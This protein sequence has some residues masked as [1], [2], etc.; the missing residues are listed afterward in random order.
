MKKICWLSDLH[1]DFVGSVRIKDFFREINERGFDYIL[2]SGDTGT[3]TPLITYLNQMKE[4]IDSQIY[5]VLGNHD[6]YGSSFNNVNQ[7]IKLYS[8]K[9]EKIKWFTDIKP[10]LIDD[11]LVLIGDDGWADAR[12]GKPFE[13][14]VDLNDFHKIEELTG[15][16]IHDRVKSLNKLGDKSAER[17]KNKLVE[18]VEMAD[19]ILIVTHV[20]PFK[21]SAWYGGLPSGDEW[22]PWF[23]SKAFG[24]VLIEFSENYKDK[25]FLVL[26]G[27]THGESDSNIRD[28][29]RVLTPETEYGVIDI[30]M[31]FD[32]SI[33][34]W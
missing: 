21:E 22:L 20:P 8:D 10:N 31:I 15:L 9:N 18:S 23:T 25:K 12:F 1:L 30:K 3:S 24:D 28:N 5:F 32:K 16:L 2:V 7:K 27:H 29:L 19:N 33:F 13:S 11:D 17:I 26:A 4:N 14:G 34:T 6:Y